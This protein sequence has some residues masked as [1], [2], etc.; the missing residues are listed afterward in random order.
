L[1]VIWGECRGASLDELD[2]SHLQHH[3]AFFSFEPDDRGGM[4]QRFRGGVVCHSSDQ[5]GVGG[6]G[7]GAQERAE[8]IFLVFEHAVLRLVCSEAGV[9]TVCAG[10]CQFCFG[11]D[12]EA[13]AGDVAVCFAADGLLAAESHLFE[14]TA[15]SADG[16]SLPF[17]A[18]KVR[19]GFLI[20]EKIP[21]F[22]L[23][24]VS[25]VL[26]VYAAKSNGTIVHL[27]MLPFSQRVENAILSYALYLKKLIW[28]VDLAV[29]YPLLDIPMHQVLPAGILL[30]VITVVSCKYY[31][32]HPYLVV[33]WFWFLGTLVPVIGI[34]QVGS[35]SMADRYAY[36]P[37]V[38]LFIGVV[39]LIADVVRG[40][41]LQ[42]I[43]VVLMLAFMLFLSLVAHRQAGYWEN[44]F[45]LFQ[46]AF[47]VTK[48]EAASSNVMVVLGNE[49][50]KQGKTDKA[51]EYFDKA[52]SS[53]VK[54]PSDYEAFVSLA[55][56][57]RMQGK[58]TEAIS[59][60][61]RALKVNPSGHEAYYRL[62]AVYF[63]AGRI[64]EATDAYRMA[65]FLKKDH[66]MYHGGLGNAFFA[67]GKMAEATKEYEEVLSIQP[68]N[69]GAHN[70]LGIVLMAQGKM[71]DAVAYFLKSLTLEPKQAN[72][73]FYLYKI[74][75][76]QGKD[77]DARN[78]YWKAVDLD[79]NS[80]IHPKSH[81]G[82]HRQK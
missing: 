15:R 52:L 16:D 30:I 33:S 50:I 13:D 32:R 34:V 67:K 55:N 11:F 62:G 23:T 4:A 6:V 31:K 42:K 36:V 78:H 71:D 26:T 25:V 20:W 57:L 43:S 49:L 70:N 21:L 80:N 39:W 40:R 82:N 24:A 54:V 2:F 65:V 58:I 37:F 59:V 51:I 19:L 17:T 7:S 5:C 3:F 75:E 22:I 14:Y 76:K 64:D 8:H 63:E 18:A 1:G 41:F 66:P 79:R 44:T 81:C 27:N 77:E 12:V 9:E 68:N 48:E 38:G 45:M 47:N 60:F 35:Q 56:A 69:I 74:F 10:F 29:F 72:I 28:P 61:H 46:R 73:H 53:G